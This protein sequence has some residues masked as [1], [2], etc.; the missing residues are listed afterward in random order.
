[1]RPPASPGTSAWRPPNPNDLSPGFGL[2]TASSTIRVQEERESA[3]ETE[4]E[5]QAQEIPEQ[6]PILPLRGVVVYPHT[7]VPLNIGQARSIKLV[8]EVVAGN[9][10]M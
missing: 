10:L 5:A 1:M 3:S 9:R 6:L 7:A 8:D 4:R 2:R